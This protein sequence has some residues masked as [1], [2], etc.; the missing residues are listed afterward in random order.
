MESSTL[1]VKYEHK[2]A[3]LLLA[4]IL[5]RAGYASVVLGMMDAEELQRFVVEAG[6]AV[7]LVKRELAD[8]GVKA[9][10]PSGE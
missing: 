6:E 7:D 4:V 8:R 3:D 10:V 2:A 1:K 9:E 5:K